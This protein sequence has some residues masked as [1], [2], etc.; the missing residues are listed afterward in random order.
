MAA[1]HLVLAFIV[2][3][4]VCSHSLAAGAADAR[5]DASKEPRHAFVQVEYADTFQGVQAMFAVRACATEDRPLSQGAGSGATASSPQ[6]VEFVHETMTP[7]ADDIVVHVI[8]RDG[9]E[10]SKHTGAADVCG[11]ARMAAAFIAQDRFAA[12]GID[13]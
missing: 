10:I 9:S 12:K 5:A 1:K 6:G 4:A 13:K 8:D 3:L 7:I 11:Y 2:E